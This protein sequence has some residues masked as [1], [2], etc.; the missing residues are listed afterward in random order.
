LSQHPAKERLIWTKEP[1]SSFEKEITL[2]NITADRVLQLLDY[3]SY[4]DL[5]RLPLPDNR[6][7]IFEK[8]I[9]EKLIISKGENFDITNLGA[10][11]F[12]KDLDA[13][14][15]LSRKAIRIIIYNGKNKL[16]T[17][18]EQEEKKGYASAFNPT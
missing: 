12:A 17:K 5:M 9:Q 13:F 4:F 7:L 1:S 18:K 10:I 8:L 14:E 3:L 15:T 2:H 6:N 11:L 16:K